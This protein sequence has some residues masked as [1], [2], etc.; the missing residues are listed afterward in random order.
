MLFLIFNYCS[1]GIHDGWGL[2]DYLIRL[3]YLEK[4]DAL[5]D[6]METKGMEN[7]SAVKAIDLLRRDQIK[8][9]AN[10]IV[11][12]LPGQITW[13]PWHKLS[14]VRAVSHSDSKMEIR[15]EYKSVH[16][17]CLIGPTHFPFVGG[18]VLIPNGT[19]LDHTIKLAEI[20][21]SKLGVKITLFKDKERGQGQSWEATFRFLLQG[22]AEVLTKN[23]LKANAQ[24]GIE[25][26]TQEN[27]FFERFRRGFALASMM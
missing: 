12:N 19:T 24:Q 7:I 13:V 9:F 18:T 4:E 11:E 16:N 17:T 21:S 27:G 8:E 20:E 5:C 6:L 15:A 22:Q 23:I 25:L 3:K 26:E 10:S 14:L 2:K 1:G